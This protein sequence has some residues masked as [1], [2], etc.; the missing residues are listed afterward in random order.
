MIINSKNLVENWYF[1]IKK[2]IC[3]ACTWAFVGAL[4]SQPVF[5]SENLSIQDIKDLSSTEVVASHKTVNNDNW[6]YKSLVDITQ[7]Y[8]IKFDKLQD[9]NNSSQPLTR[10]DAAIILVNLVGKL[11]LEQSDKYLIEA[12]QQNFS[13]EITQLASRVSNLEDTNKSTWKSEFGEN[14]NINGGVAVKYNLNLQGGSTDNPSNF[15]L[16]SVDLYFSGKLKKHLYYVTGLSPD[17]TFDNPNHS[18]GYDAYLRSDII[19]HNNI[20]A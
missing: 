12:M 16:D 5:A 15:T 1:M 19:P 4:V 6:A 3:L 18:I 9:K 14:F 10:K 17:R 20:Y 7:K 2:K 13:N 11:Q 8:G